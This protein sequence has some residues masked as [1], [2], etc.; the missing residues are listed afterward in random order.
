MM[1]TI[2]IML[3]IIVLKIIIRIR[4]IRNTKENRCFNES[5]GFPRKRSP[6][7]VPLF[8]HSIMCAFS[9]KKEKRRKRKGD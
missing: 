2:T 6:K 1:I 4:I 7:S 3:A 9:R 5:P 8:R